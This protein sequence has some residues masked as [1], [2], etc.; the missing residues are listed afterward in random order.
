MRNDEQKKVNADPAFIIHLSSFIISRVGPPR[1]GDYITRHRECHT[2]ESEKSTALD[3]SN[4]LYS[5]APS[6]L[7]EEAMIIFSVAVVAN[8]AA[9]AATAPVKPVIY[10]SEPRSRPPHFFHDW[11]PE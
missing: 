8:T 2:Q 11:F 4:M 1:A 3:H 7:L 5:A 10:E 9:A 6:I